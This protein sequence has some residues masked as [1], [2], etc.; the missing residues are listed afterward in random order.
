VRGH[1]WCYLKNGEKAERDL[2]PAVAWTTDDNVK[3]ECLL[4]LGATYRQ[5]LKDD[6]KAIATYRRVYETRNEFKQCNAAV[7]VANILHGQGKTAEARA[8]LERIDESKMTIPVYRDTLL[9]AKESLAG[10]K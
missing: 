3:G 2:Q 9:K 4:N 5:L 6:A 8:E 7:S 10:K 1:A